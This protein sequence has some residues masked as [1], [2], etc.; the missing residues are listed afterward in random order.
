MKDLWAINYK[1]WKKEIQPDSKKWRDPVIIG[2]EKL[3]L[4]KEPCYQKQ[5][6]D[7]MWFLSNYPNNIFHRARTNNPENLYELIKD[8]QSSLVREEPSSSHHAPWF[9]TILQN[10]VIKTIWYWHRNRHIDQR[11]KIENLDI[12]LCL[13]SHLIMSVV[14]RMYIGEKTVSSIND[15]GKTGQQHVKESNWITYTKCK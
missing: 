10:V 12:N 15:V 7:L 8:S 14:S 11:S 3:V 1:I 5:S 9:L 2:L 4:L 13:Y 6:T